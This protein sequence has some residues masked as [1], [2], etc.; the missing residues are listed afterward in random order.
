MFCCRFGL[1]MIHSRGWNGRKV[2]ADVR[3]IS[4]KC[5]ILC[6]R[7]IQDESSQ[8]S[9]CSDFAPIAK[10][11]SCSSHLPQRLID[12]DHIFIIIVYTYSGCD[13]L[14]VNVRKPVHSV[15]I[16]L[17]VWK[18]ITSTRYKARGKIRVVVA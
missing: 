9:F 17:G 8:R 1:M 3:L 12:I 15:L 5:H 6:H 10:F 13:W 14:A 16:R 2:L 18:V 4:L 11:C 7:G